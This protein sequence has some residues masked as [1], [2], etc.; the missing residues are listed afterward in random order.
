MRYENFL[1]SLKELD[2]EGVELIP[3]TLPPFPWY[4]G[5]QRY[6]N[7]WVDPKEIAE[8]CAKSGLRICLDISHSKLA[9]NY[10]NWSFTEFVRTV[11]PHTAHLH[12]VDARGTD[13]EGLQ[14]GEGDIDFS[15]LA[16]E[17]EKQTPQASF[18]PEI[19]QG[20]K[21]NGEGFWVA[22]DR[23]EKWF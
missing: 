20:H 8:V 10:Y 23:L 3:Q 14:V 7:L 22:L 17:L 16:E 6:C 21:N 4:L 13:S 9:C 5:G 18:I 2:T 19:W 11:G 1:G 12:I 15:A